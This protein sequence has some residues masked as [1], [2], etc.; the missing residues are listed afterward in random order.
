LGTFLSTQGTLEV[1]RDSANS[2]RYRAPVFEMQVPN[3]F[4]GR[5]VIAEHLPLKVADGEASKF[6][7]KGEAMSS[8]HA[9]N[10]K[11]SAVS[12]RQ[13]MLVELKE[14]GVDGDIMLRHPR[15]PVPRR[16]PR[17]Q[18]PTQSTRWRSRS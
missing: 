2:S 4:R 17:P 14:A 1:A 13:R 3:F 6:L 12:A 11:P 16:S 10:G 18:R 8:H 7:A 5:F 15:S 9:E